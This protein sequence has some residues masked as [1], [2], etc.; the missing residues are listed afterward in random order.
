MSAA[1][2]V[3]RGGGIDEKRSSEM[4]QLT[5]VR[6]EV[7]EGLCWITIDR[8]ERMNSFT[9]HTVD[10]LI[11]CFKR[12]WAQPDVG[13]VALTGTGERAFCTGGDP[14]QRAATADYGPS[15]T[16]VLEIETL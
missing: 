8:P 7:N 13:G 4:Q 9:A 3:V 15:H 1:W 11:H 12:A 16:G 2:R 5:D 6:Y 10:E 14:K